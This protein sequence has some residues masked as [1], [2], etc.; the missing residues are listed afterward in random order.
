MSSFIVDDETINRVVSF[1]SRDDSMAYWKKEIKTKYG[2]DLETESGK[3]Q[4]GLFMFKMNVNATSERYRG[5]GIEDFR[6]MIYHYQNTIS[7]KFQVLKSLACWLYQCA[8][9]NV[10]DSDDFKFFE[11]IKGYLAYELVARLPQYESQ[12][13][14]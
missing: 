5:D 3:E 8:E 9:G 6:S 1:I 11:S 4:L 14:S 7:N 12:V 10:A 13:W 2:F